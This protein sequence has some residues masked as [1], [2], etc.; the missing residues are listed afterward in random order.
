MS[1]IT[2][3]AYFIYNKHFPFLTPSD[4][5]LKL[6]NHFEKAT[7]SR[8][9]STLL[10]EDPDATTIGDRDVLKE[11]N[12]RIKHNPD[13]LLP[14]GY[15][16]VNEKE[17]IFNYELPEYLP[18]EESQKISIEL[19]DE[20]LYSTVG[21]HFLEALVTYENRPKVKPR[22]KQTSMIPPPNAGLQYM[23]PIEKKR[24]RA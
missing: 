23:K 12:R 24:F 3:L 2:Q 11:L 9:Q 10:Y 18:I 7:R 20:L 16:K 4:F 13:I 1:L 19:L 22:I 8:G 17:Q 5:I 21:V 14:E 15:Y 6:I